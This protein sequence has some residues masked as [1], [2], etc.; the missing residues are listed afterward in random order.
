MEQNNG[1]SLVP[2]L[3]VDDDVIDVQAITRAFKKHGI[4]NPYFIANDGLDA[5]EKLR[6]TN[7]QSQLNPLPRV[8]MLDINMP[9]MNGIEFLKE[10]RADPLLHNLIVF[11]FTSSDHEEDVISTYNLNVSGYIKKPLD[12]SGMMK[13][14]DVLNKLWSQLQYPPIP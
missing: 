5:L 2:I 14:I 13:T 11:M 9:R 8:I 4:K 10:L 1:A 6:G 12:F 7:G 3:V